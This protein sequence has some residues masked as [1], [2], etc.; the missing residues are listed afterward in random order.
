MGQLLIDQIRINGFRGLID[1]KMP[2]KRT[3]VL[4]GANNV[5]KTSV[6]KALQLALGSRA[7]IERDDY[8][9]ND[10]GSVTNEII[11]DIRIIS[12]DEF[13]NR[14]KEFSEQWEELLLA[15]KIKYD[16]DGNSYVPL[17]TKIKYE[18]I[19][20]RF[21]TEQFILNTWEN[22]GATEDWKAITA[23]KASF[24]IDEI[25]FFYQEAQRDVVDDIKLKSSFLG[26][27]ISQISKSYNSA[28]LDA[29]EDLIKELNKTTIEKSN[30][31]P[32]IKSTLNSVGSTMSGG[33]N[34]D[35]T[36]FAKKIR[37]INKSIAITYGGENNSLTMDFHGMG[38]RS[39]SSLLTLKA[40]LHHNLN[41][42]NDN[43]IVF[44]SI[45]AIEEP[46][47]H[48]HPN[49]QKK[50]YRQLNEIPGQKIIS[51]HSQYI[52]ASAEIDEV[53]VLYKT[54]SLIKVGHINK[55]SLS[56]EDLRKLQKVRYF[57]VKLLF[58]LRAKPKSKLYQY[59]LINILVVTHLN[60]E[61]ILLE[62]EEQ[63]NIYRSFVL[64]KVIISHGIY[65]AMEKILL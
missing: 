14:L 25:M 53:N 64:L 63:D 51:T 47:A 56:T 43:N 58:Y 22:H 28:D 4:T 32:L 21:K 29:L 24:S 18:P 2:L 12:T 5:G 36:P 6:L 38:T 40:F 11:I 31:L 16:E 41:L 44:F 10:D 17:R 59:L 19:N 23:K 27:M 52:A 39:W 49:A 60:S 45:V 9:I 13:D 62:S 42:S 37:D 61:S 57:L 20:E 33:E 46:E 30:I 26:K 35:I 50:L 3:T 15:D 34:I 8:H 65:S 48:L 54:S 55:D 1:F 7:F